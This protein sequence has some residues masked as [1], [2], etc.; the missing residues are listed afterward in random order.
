MKMQSNFAISYTTMQ[1][2]ICKENTMIINKYVL[3]KEP[4]KRMKQQS[5]SPDEIEY[6]QTHTVIDS[7]QHLHRT[8]KSIKMKLWRL[9]KQSNNF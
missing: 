3:G 6:I 1:P 7:M 5:W 2:S 8:E 4:K 9:N